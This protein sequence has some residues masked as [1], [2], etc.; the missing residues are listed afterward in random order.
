MTIRR[1][2]MRRPFASAVAALLAPMAALVLDPAPGKAQDGAPYCAQ[3][4]FAA[5]EEGTLVGLRTFVRDFPECPE[6][7]A[8][9]RIIEIVL[10]DVRGDRGRPPPRAERPQPSPRQ[11]LLSLF[12]S[13]RL[14]RAELVRSE[15][16]SFAW[17]LGPVF[18]ELELGGP[19]L[20]RQE[21]A[22][23]Q[24]VPERQLSYERSFE[25]AYVA[26]GRIDP[27]S[28]VGFYSLSLRD[29][30]G[31]A[32]LF[33]TFDVGRDGKADRRTGALVSEV[34]CSTWFGDTALP[35]ASR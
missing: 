34:A 7:D 24:A 17:D 33:M 26:S 9:E 29:E 35:C 4:F 30:G 12:Y 13:P 15:P 21:R 19:E 22:N 31:S 20:F 27:G 11:G 1:A 8:V 3:E 32:V 16:G 25:N 18:A 6:G 5:L 14:D 10:R 2:F 23:W 28:D